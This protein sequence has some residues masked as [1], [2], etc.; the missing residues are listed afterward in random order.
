[1]K[2]RVIGFFVCD[3]RIKERRLRFDR[4]LTR[5]EKHGRLSLGQTGVK[6][7][8]KGVT[9][10]EKQRYAVAFDSGKRS[11]K[12]RDVTGKVRL[13]FRKG[14]DADSVVSFSVKRSSGEG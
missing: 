14:A 3:G 11:G 8:D 6:S 2:A 5:A 7:A 10:I 12:M 4:R 1:M 9:L 13:R